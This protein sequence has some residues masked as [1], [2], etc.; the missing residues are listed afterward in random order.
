MAASPSQTRV[1]I[2]IEDDIKDDSKHVES[3]VQGKAGL[4]AVAKPE[5][6]AGMS[7]EELKKLEVWMVRKLDMVI[8]LV[9]VTAS[10]LNVANRAQANYRN[11]VYSELYVQAAPNPP[12]ICSIS[13]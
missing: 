9:G 4:E 13:Q 5:S 2:N 6:L 3:Q 11:P 10:T 12:C 8:M 1:S 7:D